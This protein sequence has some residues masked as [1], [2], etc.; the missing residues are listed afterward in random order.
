MVGGYMLEKEYPE[1]KDTLLLC[2]TEMLSKEDM[3]RIIAI[4]K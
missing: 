4:V 1:L 3:D 2:A